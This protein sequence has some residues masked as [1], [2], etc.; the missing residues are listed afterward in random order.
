MLLRNIRLKLQVKRTKIQL[1]FELY[2]QTISNKSI[3][4]FMISSLDNKLWTAL[5]ISAAKRLFNYTIIR[6]YSV[7]ETTVLVYQSDY[8]L[9]L[10]HFT[11]NEIY[12]FFITGNVSAYE[13]NE[14]KLLDNDNGQ[15]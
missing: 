11:A 1:P 4:Y 8:K 10:S 6:Y 13:L 12:C 2:T 9:L 15:Y 7:N 14:I 3:Q 5:E